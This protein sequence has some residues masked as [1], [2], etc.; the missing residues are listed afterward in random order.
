MT[1][2][3]WRRIDH[4]FHAALE[5]DAGSS[6]DFLR[7]ECGDDAGLFAEIWR[8]LEEHARVGM[9]DQNPLGAGFDVRA[10]CVT[11]SMYQGQAVFTAGAV[12]SDRYRIVRFISRGGM[13]EVYEAEDL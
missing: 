5:Q 6:E 7:R 9:L 13:G 10:E 1:P 3:R 4:L 12:V 11:E 8:M 2:Q